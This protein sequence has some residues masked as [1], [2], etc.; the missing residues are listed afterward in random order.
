MIQTYEKAAAGNAATIV[1]GVNRAA[2]EAGTPCETRYIKDQ[3]A[4]EESARPRR[5][6]DAISSSW[7]RTD[8]ALSAECSSAAPH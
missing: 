3:H 4:P 6:P 5:R 2:D 1:D 8:A 7:A